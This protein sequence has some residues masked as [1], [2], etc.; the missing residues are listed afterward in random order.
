MSRNCA[1]IQ[2]ALILEFPFGP[3]KYRVFRETGPGPEKEAENKRSLLYKDLLCVEMIRCPRS[4]WS[5]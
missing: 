4:V 5:M 2:K 1:T 3:E